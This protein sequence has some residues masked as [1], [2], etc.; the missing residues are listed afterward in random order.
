MSKHPSKNKEGNRGGSRHDSY[1]R[2]TKDAKKLRRNVKKATA[3]SAKSAATSLVSP[4]GMGG[5]IGGKGY[6]FQSRYIACHIPEWLLNGA[7]SAILPEGT[8]D[9]DVLYS[10]GKKEQ[11]EHIQIKDHTIGAKTEFREIV[12]TFA[13][14]D[15]GMPGVYQRF[16]LACPS[17]G[18]V[19]QPLKNALERIRNVQSFFKGAPESMKTTLTDVGNR[20]SGLG[21]AAHQDL[22]INKVYFDIGL[23][24]FHDDKKACGNFALKLIEH[25]EYKEKLIHL[26]KPAYGPLFHEVSNK[27]GKM[28][29]RVTLKS[30]IDM[31]LKAAGAEP[32]PA[33]DLD[34]H[35][36]TF[37]KYDRE[38]QY[39]IDWSSQFD[40][41]T[42][43]VPDEKLWN[44]QLVPELYTLKG[45]LARETSVRLIRLRGKNTL[46][47]GIA[48]GAAFPQIGGW[49]F[50]IPQPP[51]PTPWRSD[52]PPQ[53][54]YGLRV[55]SEIPM[56]AN[57]DS[58]AYV[59]NIKGSALKD[60]ESYIKE[61]SLPVKSIISV[62]PE[63]AAGSLSIADD[64]EALSLALSARDEL[65]R[66]LER[67][68]VRITHLFFY[69]PFALSVF[70]GQLLT[71]IGRVHLYEFKD[72][73]YVPSATIKT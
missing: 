31:A 36:W 61:N 55:G 16:I 25:P 68:N 71:A 41:G 66:A 18:P 14:F 20:I 62:E 29:D 19:I 3:S 44:E 43:T 21:L 72:P 70:I 58:I 32:E 6:D 35:N 48:L 27:R 53:M 47:T 5:I 60:V 24:D 15:K 11:R 67:N 59:F 73:G 9:V 34:V 26:I 13:S 45:R 7:F 40:R 38:P 42:R 22:I 65:R 28:L 23:T 63:G 50:E 10:R 8:G 46:T 12:E 30:L 54:K 52:A 37:E 51:M 1:S 49:I 39:V 57:G 56:D 17:V 69:G 4:S 64:R 33:I 2:G